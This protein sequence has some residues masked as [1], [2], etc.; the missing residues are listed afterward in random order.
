MYIYL[1]G[2]KK[3]EISSPLVAFAPA[4]SSSGS[5]SISRKAAT[6]AVVALSSFTLLCCEPFFFFFFFFEK[7]LTCCHQFLDTA[8]GTDQKKHILYSISTIYFMPRSDSTQQTI[9]AEAEQHEVY[10]YMI[11]IATLAAAKKKTV[12][13]SGLFLYNKEPLC[14]FFN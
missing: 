14:I 10:I 13:Y 8:K 12:F 1:G 5:R 4:V 7:L 9:L 11:I 2:E 6:A 3:V